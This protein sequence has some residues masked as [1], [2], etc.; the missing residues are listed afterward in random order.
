VVRNRSYELIHPRRLIDYRVHPS[1]QCPTHETLV[2][3]A[4]HENHWQIRSRLPHGSC[5]IET[6]ETGHDVM[7]G[8]YDVKLMRVKLDRGD[9]LERYGMARDSKAE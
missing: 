6:G 8:Y 3:V 5:H 7:V 9:S 4:A 1:R 2:D